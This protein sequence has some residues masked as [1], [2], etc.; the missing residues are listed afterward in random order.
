MRFKLQNF[1]YLGRFFHNNDICW[2]MGIVTKK[3][4]AAAVKASTT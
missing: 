4:T 1:S 2:R 3:A